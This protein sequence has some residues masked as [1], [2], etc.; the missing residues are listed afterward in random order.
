M[1]AD[2][3][4]YD[5]VAWTRLNTAYTRSTSEPSALSL[6]VTAVGEVDLQNSTAD[7]GDC[8]W[9]D[10]LVNNPKGRQSP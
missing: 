9:E 7:H 8:S 1:E 4:R 10:C 6:M 3:F 2:S 5:A